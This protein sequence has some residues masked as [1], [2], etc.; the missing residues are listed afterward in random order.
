MQQIVITG[1]SSGIGQATA[2]LAVRNG[3]RVFGSVRLQADAERL[4]SDLGSLFEP[5]CFDVRDQDTVHSEAARV[6]AILNGRRLTGLVNNAG[7]GTP[8]PL[9]HQPLSEICEQLDT[10]LLSAFIVTQAFAPLLGT[11]ASLMGPAGRIVNMSSIG[12]KVGQPFA[13]AYA[14]SKF[15]LEGFSEALRRELSIYGIAVIIMAPAL[16]NTP[17]WD[18]VAR[19]AGRYRGTDYGEAFEAAVNGIANAGREKGLDPT[20]V[21]QAV[22]HALTVRRPRLRYAPARRPL[23]EQALSRVAPSRMLDWAM[24]RT[25]GLAPRAASTRKS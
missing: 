18:R 10:N 16:V 14:A 3:A 21:A 13:T 9:I 17:I 24:T 8:G 6:R 4:R 12:G 22:W 5:L 23:L 15:G 1:V 19:R 20:T 25:L 2:R 11:D 7:T